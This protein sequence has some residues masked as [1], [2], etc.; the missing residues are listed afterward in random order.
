MQRC[1]VYMDLPRSTSPSNPKRLAPRMATAMASSH[2]RMR[3]QSPM[4]TTSDTAPMAQK[5]VRW[6]AAPNRKAS[7]KPSSGTTIQRWAVLCM[8]RRTLTV[9]LGT[10]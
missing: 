8:G 5:P 9:P 7:A 4:F 6:A 2:M 10:S 3:P 1:A